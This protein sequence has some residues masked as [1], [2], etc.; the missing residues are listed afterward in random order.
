MG[1]INLLKQN[2]LMSAKFS[3]MTPK[4]AWTGFQSMLLGYLICD[5]LVMGAYV[6]AGLRWLW[7]FIPGIG[8]AAW[9][10]YGTLQSWLG[11]WEYLGGALSAYFAVAANGNLWAAYK[12]Q[13]KG[14][15]T[16]LYANANRQL[17]QSRDLGL[18]VFA[19]PA[20][21]PHYWWPFDPVGLTQTGLGVLGLLNWLDLSALKPP[22]FTGIK[23]APAPAKKS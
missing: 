14:E 15:F 9:F 10:G 19:A 11:R 1:I 5:C 12:D 4:A 3:A 2:I 16:P 18:L 21:L 13:P 22:A 17:M 7:S 23:A 8:W 6:W 20:G